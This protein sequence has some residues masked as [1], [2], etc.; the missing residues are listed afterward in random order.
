MITLVNLLFA[1]LPGEVAKNWVRFEE[2]LEVC[3]FV[4]W[5]LMLL[6]LEGF[7]EVW[8]GVSLIPLQRRS[9]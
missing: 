8:P 5:M 2:T 6:V 1:M 7:R 3:S 4:G 9:D